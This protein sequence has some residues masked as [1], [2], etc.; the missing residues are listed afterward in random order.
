[1]IFLPRII[2]AIL[3]LLFFIPKKIKFF[4]TIYSRVAA[5]F[6]YTTIAFIMLE[7]T[8]LIYGLI[9]G[10]YIL[11]FIHWYEMVKVKKDA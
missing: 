4:T 10:I 1:M 11:S 7:I 3:F 6:V 5:L 8:I 2:T 9:I